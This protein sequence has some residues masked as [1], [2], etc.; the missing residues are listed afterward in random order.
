MTARR[1]YPGNVAR[2][3]VCRLGSDAADTY[4]GDVTLESLGW[5]YRS[6]RI[7]SESP[8]GL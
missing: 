6:C 5:V 1:V 7:G 8:A 4:A 2:F 3:R